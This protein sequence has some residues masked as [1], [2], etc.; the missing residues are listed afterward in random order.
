MIHIVQDM[1]VPKTITKYAKYASLNTIWRVISAIKH[2]KDASIKMASASTAHNHIS[3]TRNN[4]DAK[5]EDAP[6][7][8]SMAV[9]SASIHSN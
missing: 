1:P 4:K 3:M 8:A 5:L 7:I 2:P 6:D 9:R